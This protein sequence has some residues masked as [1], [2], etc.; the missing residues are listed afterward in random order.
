MIIFSTRARVAGTLP[1]AVAWAGEV[2]QIVAKATGVSIEV[3]VRAGGH[4]DIIWI[5]RL[6]NMAAV[7]KLMEQVQGDANYQAALNTAQQK[8]LFDTVNVEQAFW[9]TL[10]G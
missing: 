7:E 3:A 1:A 2:A 8:G 9:R 6:D 10:P 4:N 5:V